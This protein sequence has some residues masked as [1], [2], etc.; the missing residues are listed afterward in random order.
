MRR[1]S[2]QENVSSTEALYFFLGDHLGSTAITIKTDGIFYGEL[3]YGAWGDTA[4]RTAQRLPAAGSRVRQCPNIL[5][6]V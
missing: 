4:T 3:R 5:T 2:M 6:T 1:I